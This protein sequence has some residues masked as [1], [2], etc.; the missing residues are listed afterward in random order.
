MHQLQHIFKNKGKLN[1]RQVIGRSI[2][3]IASS[4]WG[5]VNYRIKKK[6]T[7]INKNMFTLERRMWKWKVKIMSNSRKQS[8]TSVAHSYCHQLTNTKHKRKRAAVCIESYASTCTVQYMY[9]HVR[10]E[11]KPEPRPLTESLPH[12]EQ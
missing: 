8:L 9:E 1:R 12:N 2:Y 3:R 10:R 5:K 4:I 11:E 7:E 6:S